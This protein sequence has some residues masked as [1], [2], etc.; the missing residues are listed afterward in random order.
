MRPSILRSSL[1]VAILLAALP[2]W[3][4]EGQNRATA[5]KTG[6]FSASPG[7]HLRLATDQGDIRIL[8]GS[9]SQVSYRVHL[10][11][12]ASDANAQEILNAFVLDA[13]NDSDGVVLI[14]RSPRLRWGH[15]LWV[16]LE[17]TVP[18]NYNVDLQTEGGNVQIADVQGRVSAQT[19]GGNISVG[20]IDGP[21]RLIT[22]GGHIFAKN[23]GGDLTAQTGGG[24]I[25]VG[26]VGGG[27]ILRT[28]GGHIRVASI[29]GAG[30]LDTGGGDISLEH[31]GAGLAVST[32][33][34]EIEVGEAS[35][36]IRA[37]T[38]GGGIRVVKSSGPTE[39]ETGAGSVYLMQV[40]SA[41]RATTGAGGITAWFGPDAKLTSA[42]RLAAGE[43]DIDVY[44]PKELAVT[45]DAQVELGGDHRVVVDPAFPLK[46]SYG[47]PDEG[48]QVV[49]A[50]GALNGGGATLVLRTVS[51]NIRLMLNDPEHERK[52][53][54]QLRQSL[55]R[56]Q[57]QLEMNLMKIQIPQPQQPPDRK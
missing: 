9:T 38:G 7:G 14:G 40:Q 39:L 44:I 2:L 54:E 42:C 25:T 27:A 49:R 34:G 47:E 3:A 50:E 6:Q 10:E 52:Q 41:V 46:V 1:A 18:H 33:G 26:S 51:G 43:G 45:V 56:M 48:S 30:R 36:L 17:V 53:M 12:E 35:G 4:G 37:R 28:G 21:A 31:A 8:T 16:T 24:D 29:A 23:V 32:G 15:H 13:R 55:E 11:T 22:D 57:R 19:A 20:Q 5:N